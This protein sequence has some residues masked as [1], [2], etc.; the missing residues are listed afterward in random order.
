MKATIFKCKFRL[1]LSIITLLIP[2]TLTACSTPSGSTATTSNTAADASAASEQPVLDIQSI[3]AQ[4][5]SGQQIVVATNNT[6]NGR[7]Q[8]LADAARQAGFN[9]KLVGLG[10]G[11]LTARVIGEVNNPTLNVVWGP[12]DTMFKS[13]SNAGALVKWT[14]SWS[15]QL[16]DTQADNG[17]GWSYELQPKLLIANPKLYT[18]ATAPTS[19]QDLWQKPQY[20]GKYAVPTDFSGTTNRAI[21]GGILAQY[22]DPK[23]ELGVSQ[24]GWDAI[25]QY[26][27]YGY[28]TPKGEKDLQN[29]VDGK[30]PITYIYASGLKSFIDTYHMQPLIIYS[31]T[32]EPTNT[33]QLGVV[34]N[35]NAAVM[36]ESIRFA[37]W[38]GSARMMADYAAKYGSIVVNRQAQAQI[39]PFMQQIMKKS[40]P[41]QANWTD[42]NSMMDQW[43]AKIQLEY[44]K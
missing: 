34:K 36:E 24:A 42:I 9:I 30:V 33:N 1:L 37:N 38:L 15:D 25:K 31:T 10:G 3:L 20:H 6:G 39:D 4:K 41:E 32:G 18:T 14:P 11:D 13:M 27:Q 35:S 22:V 8:W 29:L 21:I 7:D 23:G 16:T 26:F 17:Y 44:I 43:V 2:V 5:P 12:S 28:Q 19:Y 40:K